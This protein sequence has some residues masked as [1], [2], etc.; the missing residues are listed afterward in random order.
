MWMMNLGPKPD[1]FAAV[2][3]LLMNSRQMAQENFLKTWAN[4]VDWAG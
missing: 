4:L 1:M 3:A 2:T